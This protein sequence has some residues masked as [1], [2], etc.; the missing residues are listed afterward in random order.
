MAGLEHNAEY[1]SALAESQRLDRQADSLADAAASLRASLAES[2]GDKGGMT[3]EILQIEGELLSLRSRRTKIAERINAIEYEWL[4]VN[5]SATEQPH[6]SSSA[7]DVRTA[8][9]AQRKR[10]ANLTDNAMFRQLLSKED[11]ATLMRAQ[12]NETAAELL[13]REYDGHYRALKAL[14]M[15]YDTAANESAADSLLAK[16]R[17]NQYACARLSDSLAAVW[18]YTFDNKTYIYELLFDRDGREDLLSK[19]EENRQ[20]MRH[21]V[22][23]ATGRYASDAVVEY[24]LGKRCILDYE[25]DMAAAAGLKEASDSL[26]AVRKRLGSRK[27]DY[28]TTGISPRSFAVYEPLAF[29]SRAHYGASNPIPECTI[30][31][32]GT[33]YRIRLEKSVFQQ[34]ASRYKGLCPV[35]CLHSSDGTWTY[36]A[37]GYETAEEAAADL[38]TVKRMGFRSAVIAAWFDGEYAEGAAR[39]AELESRRYAV[40]IT[41]ADELSS[42]VRQTIASAGE[43]MSVSRPRQGTFLVGGLH[44]ASAAAMLADDINASYPSLSATVTEMPD[45]K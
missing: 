28:E 37:G 27:Y 19:A 36:Y 29:S 41:G 23:K 6:D 15:Q 34:P 38:N 22:S 45:A 2:G 24:C 39:I 42:R 18:D 16:F 31:G 14:R 26:A 43:G 21:E 9:A 4:T 40:E 35:S 10:H 5:M 13:L 7:E 32:H 3:M 11:Y 12:A 1:M 33:I 44:S 17:E 8:A 20:R 30:C 25:S